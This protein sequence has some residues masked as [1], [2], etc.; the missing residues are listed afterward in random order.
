MKRI[1]Y[2]LSFSFPLVAIAQEPADALRYGWQT[3]GATARIQA[4]GGAMGSLGGDITATFVNPAGLAFY[5]TGDFVITPR[6]Q[7]GRTKAKYL[8]REESE[9]NNRFNFGT[10]GVVFGGDVGSAKGKVKSAA[11]SLAYNRTAD[12]NSNFM[13]RGIN[14]KSS[15]SQKYLEEIAANNDRDANVVSSNIPEGD[16][17]F[18]PNYVYGTSLAFNTY[19][20][21]TVGGSTNGNFRFQSRAAN[22]LSGGLLQQQTVTTSGGMHEF[23]F[24]MAVNLNDKWMFGGTLGV[25]VIAY[26]R[27]SEFVEADPTDNKN[28]FDYAS[29]TEDFQTR[30]FGFNLKLGAIYKPAEFWRVGLAIHTPSLLT[31]TDSYNYSVT[32]NN[33][34]ATLT[35]STSELTGSE[36]A[37]YRYRFVTP[38]RII[39]S[40]S[41]V[42]REIEDV[43]KQRGFITADVEYVNY[44]ATSFS[45]HDEFNNGSGD[46]AYLNS[47]NQA[48]DKAYKGAFNFRVGGELKFT[49][50]MV[51]LGAAYFGNP[52]RD[53]KG[54]FGDRLNLTGGLGYRNKGFFVDVAYVHSMNR[55]VH[56]AYRLSNADYAGAT[57]R[58]TTGNVVATLGLKF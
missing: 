32:T 20:I 45:T 6:F 11:I 55:D 29:V 43:R 53:I 33:D 28:K 19:W 58:N 57:L 38:Y 5:R 34:S 37:Q 42:L 10:T 14:T 27:R 51:R 35:Q 16:P 4:I 54:E 9:R 18:R 1:L 31:L 36:R 41:Y 48:I 47:L 46:E 49:T 2:I 23:A 56:F 44:S 22:L 7:W 25:P 17:R 24:G 3:P 40:I 12:F 52:Y 39:G 50:L 8:D 21:D 30:G 13:Y 15:Y 26:N